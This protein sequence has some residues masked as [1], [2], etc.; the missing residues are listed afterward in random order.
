VCERER[1]RE[2]ERESKIERE[3]ETDRHWDAIYLENPGASSNNLDYSDFPKEEL[4]NDCSLVTS[5]P[6]F[7]T[8]RV[9]WCVGLEEV[10]LQ[11]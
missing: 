3:R 11:I 6:I 5:S 1:E 9:S 8:Q 10:V 7:A 2:R 4:R